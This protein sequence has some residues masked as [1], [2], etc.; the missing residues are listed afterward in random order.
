VEDYALA[1]EKKAARPL[2]WRLIIVMLLTLP[3]MV[4]AEL[5]AGPARR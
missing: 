4:A 2:I 1:E 3:A 5:R